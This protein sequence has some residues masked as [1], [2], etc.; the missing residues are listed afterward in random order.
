[1]PFAICIAVLVGGPFLRDALP[2]GWDGRWLYAVQ[3]GAVMLALIWF[4]R[5]YEELRPLVLGRRDALEAV[6]AGVAVFVLW[7]NFDFSWAMVGEPGAEFDPRAD[8]GGIDWALV[9]VRIFGAA[10]VVPIME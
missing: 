5:A 4:A 1:M 3:I 6:V 9:A 8:G 10:A 7:I 2:P